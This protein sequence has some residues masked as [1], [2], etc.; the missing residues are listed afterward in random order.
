MTT[1]REQ[2]IR[3]ELGDHADPIP[4]SQI[5]QAIAEGTLSDLYESWSSQNR[6][7]A[8]ATRHPGRFTAGSC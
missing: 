6:F 7:L 3:M 2:I 4:M 8:K 5:Q 1:Q